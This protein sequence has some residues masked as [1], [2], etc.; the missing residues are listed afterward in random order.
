VQKKSLRAARTGE[1]S[2]VRE[3]QSVASP[4]NLK[5]FVTDEG[6]H[7]FSLSAAACDK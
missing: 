7:T 6:L 5:R 3:F 4:F 2:L 1:I